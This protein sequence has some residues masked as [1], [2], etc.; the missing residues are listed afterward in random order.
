MAISDQF[1]SSGASDEWRESSL[2]NEFYRRGTENQGSGF[3]Y[4]QKMWS[5]N[6][7]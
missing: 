5:G 2:P 1:R 3:D 6:M 7:K 4:V